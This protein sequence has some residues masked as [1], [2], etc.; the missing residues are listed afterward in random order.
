MGPDE[1]ADRLRQRFDDVLVARGDVNVTVSSAD[2]LEAIAYLHDED[3]LAFR[4]LSDV[5]CSDWP[6]ADPR[7]WLAYHLLSM[8]HAH[9]VRVKVGLPPAPDPPHVVSLTGRFP[10]ANWLE[11]EVFD[12]FGVVFDGHPDLRRIEMPEDWV[13]HPLRKDEPLAGVNTRYKGDAFIPPPDQRG[14]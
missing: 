8:E 3:D 6:G 7:F 10:T 2:L 14:T 12:F 13:G 11:R 5:T 4:F 9:R 1:L